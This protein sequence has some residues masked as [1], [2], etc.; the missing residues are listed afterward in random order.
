MLPA[1]RALKPLKKGHR[2]GN[3]GFYGDY[4][5]QKHTVL[6]GFS[7]YEKGKR[8]LRKQETIPVNKDSK[9]KWLVLFVVQ[10]V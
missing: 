2:F 6:L 7:Q 1:K 8:W 5:C 4:S 3:C 10:N 9:N